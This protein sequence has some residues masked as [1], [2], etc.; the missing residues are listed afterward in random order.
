M[1]TGQLAPYIHRLIAATNAGGA[2]W[3][4]TNP[5]TLSWDVE[6]A[7]PAQVILQVVNKPLRRRL[8]QDL[9]EVAIDRYYILQVIDKA[10]S[11]EVLSANG[12]TDAGLNGLLAMLFNVATAAATKR[13]LDFL[14]AI[15]P[16]TAHASGV[17]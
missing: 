17:K 16:P 14:D 4:Q 6:A 9:P 15:I 13:A 12:S 2:R 10:R 11:E 8:G 1:E 7:P 3:V 5:S